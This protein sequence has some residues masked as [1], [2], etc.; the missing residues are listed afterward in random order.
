MTKIAKFGRGLTF[1]VGLLL[2]LLT[3]GANCADLTWFSDLSNCTPRS[4]LLEESKENHWRMI[5]YESNEVSGVLVSANPDAPDLKLK[6][7][8]KG[9]HAV[10]VGLWSNEIAGVKLTDDPC[11]TRLLPE[12]PSGRG[13]TVEDAFFKYADLTDQDLIIAANGKGPFGKPPV[14]S[15]LAYVRCQPLSGEQVKQVLQ[16]RQRTDAQR[17]LI[18][19]NDGNCFAHI[20]TPEDVWEYIEGYRYSDVGTLNWGIHGELCGYPTKVG[21]DVRLFQ[22]KGFTPA[23]IDLFRK[24]F[25]PFKIALDYAHSIG[26]KF[27]VYQRMG[28]FGGIPPFKAGDIY[29]DEE[30]ETKTFKNH[31]E[32]RCIDKQGRPM[33][34]LSYA[35]PGFRK[36]AISILREAAEYGVDG[37]NLHFKR[38]APFVM[39][40]PPLLEEFQE[41]TGLNAQELDEWDERW[42]RYRSWPLT[43][44]LRE[45][46]KVLDQVGRKLD[47]QLEI[48]VAAFPA[49]D[50]NLF[51]GLDLETWI[52]ED[53]IDALTPMGLS[54]A[55]GEVELDYFIG[56]TNGTKCRFYPF[57]GTGLDASG[58]RR[59]R[60][61]SNFRES[62]L[63]AY[64]AGANGLTIWD[65]ISVHR[66]NSTFGLRRLGHLEELEQGPVKTIPQR[67]TIQLVSL[68]G[69]DLRH[70]AVP[71]DY[72]RIYK[73][74]P[75]YWYLPL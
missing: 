49:K 47:K 59:P 15:S 41:Q 66:R 62:A 50:E 54:H 8:L 40:E 33:L 28:A 51:F 46:R 9:W 30:L 24:G 11:F 10:Y 53:L 43:E 48:S 2:Y 19:T 73:S 34:R 71:S 58:N 35:Y 16:D 37:V 68:G 25:N 23:E 12:K 70:S 13:M 72:K 22:H 20:R 14:G 7:C 57:L 21:H 29:F 64:R 74:S 31:P 38:G 42:L 6:L 26:L 3:T 69:H 1:V 45:L 18:A 52:N 27:F 63:K 44:F 4:A 17:R 56:L 32:W 61:A 65:E 39:Y 5:E 55:S 75:A 60:S 36:V 67:R